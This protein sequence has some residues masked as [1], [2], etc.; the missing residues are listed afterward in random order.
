MHDPDSAEN[1][2]VAV[3][4]VAVPVV[5]QRQVPVLV[6]TVLKTAEFAVGVVAVPVVVQRQ[7][8]VLV[9]TVL[10]LWRFHS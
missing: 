4:V 2:G 5:V 6:Q 3:G 1:C 9:Q 10:K 8:P 7:V